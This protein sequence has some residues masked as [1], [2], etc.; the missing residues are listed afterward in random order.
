M[1]MTTNLSPE[2]NLQELQKSNLVSIAGPAWINCSEYPS[3]ESNEFKL[4]LHN[5]DEL[6][7]HV[8]QALAELK[9]F[10]ESARKSELDQNKQKEIIPKLQAIS[11]ITERAWT[12]IGNLGVFVSTS[13][14]I[15]TSDEIAQKMQ[16][17]LRQRATQFAAALTPFDLFLA[18]AP[19]A[20]LK[21]YLDHPHTQPETFRWARER[22][23]ADTHLTEAEEELLKR[24]RTHSLNA[25]GQLYNQISGTLRCEVDGHEV[26]LAQAAGLLRDSN[27]AIRKSAWQG[28]QN[29]WKTHEKSGAAILNG[30]AGWRI[31]EC[32]QRSRGGR[33]VDYLTFPV[34]AAAIRRETLEAMNEAVWNS[35][36]VGQRALKAMAAS[37]GK[38][39]ADPW[40]LLAGAPLN[41]VSGETQRPYK[42]GLQMVRDAFASVDSSFAGFV[43]MMEKNWWIEGRVL[44]NKRQGAYCTHFSKSRTP[45]VFMTYMGSINDIRTLAHELGHA[46]HFWML[47]DLPRAEQNY[48]I[49]LAETASIFAETVLAEHIGQ[50]KN[51]SMGFEIGWQDAS[52]AVSHLLNIPSRFEF[53]KNFYERRLTNAY[54]SPEELNELMADAWRKWY[55][56]ALT[57][58]ERQFW[59]TKLHFSMSG[60]SFYNFPYTFGSLF[61]LGIYA[62]RALLGDAFLPKYIEI[63]RD[64]G[65]MTAE[66]LALKHLGEDI[67]KPEFW[68][69]S[70]GVI[71]K[72]VESFEALAQPAHLRQ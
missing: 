71:K 56:D 72:R 9:P 52:D 11:E 61:S 45:R 68:L 38:D 54:C 42:T 48:S 39:K 5:F 32:H 8:V 29:A 67:T 66:D 57:E 7:K 14:D 63:L 34:H 25:F 37:M 27:E 22:E 3:I 13:L 12:L 69:K 31:E 62:Q 35:R 59:M 6:Q 18:R 33:K 24:F 1:T 49:T 4:D 51:S 10:F 55:G 53:E 36:L 30:L 16:A 65:R 20:V 2:D 50:S 40:D 28:I 19:E 64:T 60:R 44:P 47:R 15:D 21:D 58:P 70:I 26:G 23:V 17:Q 41:R 43:D 46:Y